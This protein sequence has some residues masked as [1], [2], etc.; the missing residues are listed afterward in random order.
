MSAVDRVEQENLAE[1]F[2]A[3]D[4][5]FGK[6]ELDYEQL[7]Q[8]RNAMRQGMSESIKNYFVRYEEIHLRIQN[9]LDS[10][11]KEYRGCLRAL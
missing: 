10:T 11:A 4:I 8:Q 5:A 1:I 7:L 9:S 3:L 2:N 6:L